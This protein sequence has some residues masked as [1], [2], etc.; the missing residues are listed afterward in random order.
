[1]TRDEKAAVIAEVQR[2]RERCEFVIALLLPDDD[3]GCAHPADKV[4][5]EDTLD[6]EVHPYTCTLCGEESL[7][8]FPSLGR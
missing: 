1:M 3:A 4:Q 6:D 5:H 7:T 2:I 8:P